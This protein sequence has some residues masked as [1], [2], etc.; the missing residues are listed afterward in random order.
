M[1]INLD[2]YTLVQITFIN[3]NIFYNFHLF[4]LWNM[5]ISKVYLFLTRTTNETIYHRKILNVM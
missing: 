3:R 1:Y 4:V 2:K 5:L